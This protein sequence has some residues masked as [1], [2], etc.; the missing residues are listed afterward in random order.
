MIAKANY[1]GGEKTNFARPKLLIF[2]IFN[3]ITNNATPQTNRR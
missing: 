1:L 2:S 3:E